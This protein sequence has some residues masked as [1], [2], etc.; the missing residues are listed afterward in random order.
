MKK[1]LTTLCALIV[2]GCAAKGEK[3]SAELELF[4]GHL[5]IS[6]YT[7]GV[8]LWGTSS[9]GQNA[10]G[11]LLT[12]NTFEIELNNGTWNFVAIGWDGGTPMTGTP[13]CAAA[14]GIALNG[15]AVAV[16]LSLSNASCADSIISSGATPGSYDYTF[17]RLAASICNSDAPLDGTGCALSRKGYAS[18]V[19]AFLPS[20]VKVGGAMVNLDPTTGLKGGCHTVDG[21]T[22]GGQTLTPFAIPT[23]GAGSPLFTVVRAYMGDED[24]EGVADT[25]LSPPINYA[26][27]SG[28]LNGGSAPL[29]T[30]AYTTNASPYNHQQ[31]NIEL[32]MNK[33]TLCTA[34]RIAASPFAAGE[35][36]LGRPYVICSL[37]Q[38]DGIGG[39]ANWPTNSSKHFILGK[40]IDYFTENGIDLTTLAAGSEPTY[41]DSI[42]LGESP[43]TAAATTYEAIFDGR[44]HKIIGLQIESYRNDTTAIT[45]V[46]FVRNIGVNGVVKNLTFVVPMV[47]MNS[48]DKQVISNNMIGIVAGKNAGKIQNIKIIRGEVRGRDEIGAVAGR[49]IGDIEDVQ[50]INTDVEGFKEVGGI[51]G[52]FNNA[53]SKRIIRSSFSGELEATGRGFCDNA[54]YHDQANCTSNSGVWYENAHFGGIVGLLEA[55]SGNAELDQ[56]SSHGHIESSEYIGGLVG[57]AYPST[58]CLIVNSYSDANIIAKTSANSAG[59]IGYH[60]GALT[61]QYVLRPQGSAISLDGTTLNQDFTSATTV[62]QTYSIAPVTSATA[63]T[64]DQMRTA[65]TF[66]SFDFTTTWTHNDIGGDYPQLAFEAQR[67]CAGYMSATPF[68]FGAG[69]ESDPYRICTKEHLKNIRAYFDTA[70]HFKLIRDI[71]LSGETINTEGSYLFLDTDNNAL[72]DGVSSFNGTLNGNDHTISGHNIGSTGKTF[73][74]EIAITGV[75]KNLTLIPASQNTSMPYGGLTLTNKGLIDRVEVIGAAT[76]QNS[77]G[78]LTQQNHGVITKSTVICQLNVTAS[79]QNVGGLT[80]TDR[81]LILYNDVEAE[82]TI[83]PSLTGLANI[84]G[85]VGYSE[86]IAGVTHDDP[87]SGNSFNNAHSTIVENEVEVKINLANNIVNSIGGV[88]GKADNATIEDNQIYPVIISDLIPTNG[89]FAF[90][91]SF[92]LS[93]DTLPTTPASRTIYKASVG[94]AGHSTLGTISAGEY[95]YYDPLSTTWTTMESSFTGVELFPDGTGGGSYIPPS[96]AVG[97]VVGKLSDGSIQRNYINTRFEFMTNQPGAFINTWGDICGLNATGNGTFAN[98]LII[99]DGLFLNFNS[100]ACDDTSVQLASHLQSGDN[101]YPMSPGSGTITVANAS[102]AVTGV[103][104]FFTSEVTAGDYLRF[105]QYNTIQVSSITDDTNLTL[106]ATSPESLT[107]VY[108][109]VLGQM[110]DSSSSLNFYQTNLLWSVGTDWGSTN[111]W[112]IESGGSRPFLGRAEYASEHDYT[113]NFIDDYLNNR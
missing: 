88:V 66:G 111:P 98:N 8:M 57:K 90:G 67:S 93:A 5:A 54:S 48:Y 106:A 28:L 58:N 15:T 112:T 14:K 51:A 101:L 94:N 26:F 38:L 109:Y 71:D 113:A 9:D 91:G 22:D 31:A 12:S 11:Q 7:G 4:S 103:S 85:V 16:D 47:Q 50:V 56:V 78:C 6:S 64:Y 92:D 30:G 60:D 81:G 45:Q 23:G 27:P 72:P 17:P 1:L 105:G 107:G 77:G 35:G 34:E 3:T 18:S 74:E 82:I 44:G 29:Y 75:V 21:A 99:K 41:P 61:V 83:A 110:I 36:D 10:F 39:N 63:K 32:A 96:Q 97:R 49:N 43:S 2:V 108:Y 59:L 87:I 24:C 76:I 70:T 104:T 25:A 46:G 95:F 79:A 13:H 100:D 69:T 68:A 42:P 102:S 62:T 73:I 40:S 33:A 89:H 53:G 37:D 80:G 84:G 55:C 52:V 86:N 65:A 20:Y 19:Q